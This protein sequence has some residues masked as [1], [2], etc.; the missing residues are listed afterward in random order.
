MYFGTDR[1]NAAFKIRR[2][3]VSLTWHRYDHDLTTVEALNTAEKRFGAPLKVKL[4][5]F[6]FG[7]KLPPLQPPPP[8]TRSS[9]TTTTTGHFLLGK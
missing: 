8:P 9:Q 1:M 5:A 7:Q 4:R 3:N 6:E 2:I